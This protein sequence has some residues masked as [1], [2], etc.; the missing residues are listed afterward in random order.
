MSGHGR[1]NLMASAKGKEPAATT[2]PTPS[3]P[4]VVPPRKTLPQTALSQPQI[5][6]AGSQ[7]SNNPPLP[8]GNSRNGTHGSNTWTSSSEHQD[9]P[10]EDD[11]KD[12]REQFVVAYNRLAQRHGIRPLV[13]GD[14]PD[15]AGHTDDSLG[16]RRGS[17]FSK[18]LRQ[19]SESKQSVTRPDKPSLKHQ[20][21]HSIVHNLHNYKR[22]GLK[23][24]DLQALVRFCGKSLL[25]LPPDY[26]PFSLTLPTCF[27]ALAQAL[28]QNVTFH[29]ADTKGIFRV[30]G[31]ARAIDALYDYYCTDSNTDDVSRTTRCPT[32][33]AHIRCNTHDVAGTF[34]RL[35]AGLPGGILGSLS[36]FDALVAIH[37]Q[38][39]GD[40]ESRRTKESRLRARLIALAIGTVKSQYQRELICA[41]FGLLCLVGRIAKNAPRE[42]EN[43]HPLPTTDLMGYHA[44]GIVF[45]PL[46]VGDLINSYSMKVADPSAGLVLLPV[47][48]P[49]SRKEGHQNRQKHKRKHKRTNDE[50][51]SATSPLTMDRI[52]IANSIT[53]MLIVHWREVVRQIRDT[54]SVKARQQAQGMQHG[55]PEVPKDLS[56]SPS[57]EFLFLK[58]PARRDRG[59]QRSDSPST[60]SSTSTLSRLLGCLGM[61]VIANGIVRS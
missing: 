37:S 27:R 36:L 45:G 23:N 59:T 30:S 38:L 53:E 40:P 33:P 3:D 44:L 6:Q 17:W 9:L 24:L 46:L 12:D 26:A 2:R 47:F 61:K 25:F 8:E 31:S 10:P 48:A 50:G 21:S 55:H 15:P 56:L 13:P 5:T 43:G 19:P 18:M 14:F 29:T 11:G 54:G 16:T 4:R 42:D 7:T 32:L 20:R 28:V 49:R 22:D 35:L 60:A 57:A 52:H 39:Q 41:V 34:K 51:P 58:D 1:E